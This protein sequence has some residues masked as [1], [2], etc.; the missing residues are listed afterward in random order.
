MVL[1]I[2]II[3]FTTIGSNIV[4]DAIKI[5]YFLSMAEILSADG[6]SAWRR[7]LT[8]QA[9]ATAAIDRDLQQAGVLPL[10]WY[11]VLFALHEAPD[12]CLRMHQLAAAVVLSRSGLTRLVDRLDKAGFVTRSPCPEDRRGQHAVL[13]AE[14]KAA[15]RKTWPVYSKSIREHFARHYS[16]AEARRI[17]ALLGRTI[18]D[19]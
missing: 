12:N 14:G 15:L 17:S 19:T 4:A 5:K 1:A 3:V 6:L 2:T 18:G 9:R 13:T 11:D 10:S 8:A 16:D 7:L